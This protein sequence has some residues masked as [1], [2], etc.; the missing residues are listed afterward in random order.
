VDDLGCADDTVL[1]QID[2]CHS[3]IPLSFKK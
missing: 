3:N 1:T 2:L